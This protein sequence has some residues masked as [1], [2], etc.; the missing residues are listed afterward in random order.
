MSP[1]QPGKRR[2]REKV[3]NTASDNAFVGVQGTVIGDVRYEVK[4]GDTPTRKFEVAR[5]CLSGRMSPRAK[6]LI[7]EAIAEGLV[8]AGSSGSLANKVAYHLTIAVLSDQTFELLTKEEFADLDRARR[9]CQ[10]GPDDEWRR[11]VQSV[12]GLIAYLQDQER[13]GDPNSTALDAFYAAFDRLPDERRAEIRRHL[14][15]IL[16]GV[17]QDR[18]DASLTDVMRGKRTADSR[19]KRVWKF[20]EPVPEA[21]RPKVLREHAFGLFEQAAT[22][23]GCVMGVAGA[24]LALRLCAFES[25]K[26]TLIIIPIVL[27]AG[28]IVACLAPARLPARYSALHPRR[29]RPAPTEFSASVHASVE[30]QFDKQTPWAISPEVWEAATRRIRTLLADDVV[31]LYS[32]PEVAPGAVDWLIAW[33]AWAAAR[34]WAARELVDTL[35][36]LKLLV[37]IVGATGLFIGCLVALS[38][39]LKVQ[40]VIALVAVVWLMGGAGLLAWS[41]ADVRLVWRFTYAD[42]KKAAEDRYGEEEE[43]FQARRAVLADRPDDA[44]M[45]QWLDYDKMYL[46]TLAMNQYGLANRDVIAHATLT[47][48]GAN[49]RRARVAGGQPRFSSYLVWVFLLTKSGARQV[50]VHLDFPTGIASD[51]DRTAFRYDAIASA[52]VAELGVRFDDGRR[53]IILPHT[54]GGTR[55]PNTSALIFYQEFHLS[56]TNGQQIAIKLENF[57]A[58]LLERL[59]DGEEPRSTPD[60]SDLTGALSLLEAVAADG[61]KWIEQ[62]RIRHGHRPLRDDPDSPATGEAPGETPDDSARTNHDGELSRGRP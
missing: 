15:L 16:N 32:D 12:T 40:P 35:R 28:A 39:M 45:A 34:R 48:A 25:V 55:R 49:A 4:G 44:E 60:L 29:P 61:R 51:Q 33:H 56:L 53:E 50:A 59:P 38:E 54:D 37:L 42:E 7:D 41:H 21:P 13:N 11:A 52:R 27:V 5:A 10:H 26:V 22:L 58:T 47:E 1:D 19:D 9:L 36:P 18:L 62:A 43:A 3:T 17:I 20:F 30:R 2:R 46:K 14:D 8:P 31:D 23:C 6:Q 24:I 57:D